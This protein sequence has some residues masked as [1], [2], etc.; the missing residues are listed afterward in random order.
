[1]TLLCPKCKGS[2]EGL[3]EG[4]RGGRCTDCG[5]LW[6]TEGGLRHGILVF[7]KGLGIED[8]IVAFHEIPAGATEIACPE[9]EGERLA[10]MKFRGVEVERCRQCGM[11]FLDEGETD[12]ISQRVLVSA[13]RPKEN[14]KLTDNPKLASILANPEKFGSGGGY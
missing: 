4:A 8:Q 9:C 3:G 7:L 10:R 1:M 2:M 5:G 13:R 11:I 14:R 12:L 6:V